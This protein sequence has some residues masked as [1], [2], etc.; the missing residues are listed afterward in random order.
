MSETVQDANATAEV[1]DVTSI[2]YAAFLKVKVSLKMGLSLNA[3]IY[4]VFS[5]K[6]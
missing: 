3:A 6:S 2:D 4:L 1:R 5:Q